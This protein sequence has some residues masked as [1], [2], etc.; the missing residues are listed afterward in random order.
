MHTRLLS[1]AILICAHTLL[2]GAVSLG[3]DK[4]EPP[5][6]PDGEAVMSDPDTA[7]YCLAH[8][9]DLSARL[10]KAP[11]T[12]GYFNWTLGPVLVTRNE[13]WGI[14][15]RID[16]TMAGYDVS[17][18]VNRLVIYAGFEKI[19]VMVAIGEDIAPLEVDGLA[20]PAY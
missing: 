9:R 1:S 4:A 5:L 8:A 2:S 20:I 10:D 12:A 17:P 3:E 6:S 19:S 14:V 15:C 11:D 7:A 13:A 16:F 18:R